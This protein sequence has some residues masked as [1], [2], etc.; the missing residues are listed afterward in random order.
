MFLIDS[1]I[2]VFNDTILLPKPMSMPLT[3]APVIMASAFGVLAGAGVYAILGRL[4]KRPVLIFRIVAI[5]VLLFSFLQPAIA[6][7]GAPIGFVLG[8]ELMHLIAGTIA[9]VLLTT[10]TAK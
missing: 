7:A 4:T 5:A 3:I 8:L 6:F 1:A 2:G 10:R 9:I